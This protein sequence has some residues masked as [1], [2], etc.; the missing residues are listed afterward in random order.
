MASELIESL[1]EAYRAGYFPMADPDQADRVGWFNPDP[2]AIIPL[3]GSFRVSRSLRQRVRSGRFDIRADSAF[4]EVIRACARPRPDEDQTWISAEIIGAYCALHEAG[5]A[6]SVEA[7]LVDDDGERLVG[8]LYGVSIAGL[9]AGESMFS[10]PG[11]GGTDS[12]KV[13]L[14]HLVRH[15]ERRGMSLL[16][17]Q[18]WNPHLDQFGCVMIRRDE[19]LRRLEEA[20][21][22]DVSFGPFEANRIGS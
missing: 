1:L 15:M 21:G 8:G 4:D 2:R 6:H 22:L 16:D 11:L 10:L 18:F 5:Y 12:S 9:F 19:Y 13:C 20:L 3:D 14:V 7:W 17:T